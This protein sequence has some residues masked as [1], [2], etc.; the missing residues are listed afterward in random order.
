MAAMSAP[1][2]AQFLSRVLGYDRIRT[3]QERLKEKRSA[4]RA[5]LDVLRTSLG[6][7]AELEAGERRAHER[8][9]AATAAETASAE[10][11]A[12]VERRLAELRPR[13]E[14]LQQLRDA[15]MRLEAETR[16]ADHE[17]ATAEARVAQLE[18]QV[19]E[20]D[21]GGFA[22]GRRGGPARPA[23]DAPRGGRGARCAGRG[24]M[25]AGRD[26]SR[27]SPRSA[28]TSRRWTSASPGC[29]RKRPCR[30]R[31]SSPRSCAPPS[32]SYR[33]TPRTP[34]PRGCATRRTPRPSARRCSTITTSCGNSA[35]AWS[36]PGPRAIAPPA[37]VR[38]APSTA[39]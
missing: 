20:A 9:A 25:R 35:T 28:S 34:G 30:R 38:S 22:S 8:R 2:R 37:P 13:A 5:R 27:S 36:T 14:R 11:W 24:R 6:D 3:A 4:L 19:A 29:R 12:G 10:A 18:K 26:W 39:T 1:E 16:V 15:A 23:A 33:S 21:V 7:P 32:R 31:G 17:V